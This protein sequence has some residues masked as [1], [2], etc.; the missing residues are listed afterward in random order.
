[1]LPQGTPIRRRLRPGPYSSG[2]EPSPQRVSL[3]A[4]PRHESHVSTC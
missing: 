2:G 3:V 1:M 4:A